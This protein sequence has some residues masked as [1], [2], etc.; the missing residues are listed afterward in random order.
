MNRRGD[1]PD[2]EQRLAQAQ[3]DA[4]SSSNELFEAISALEQTLHGARHA[5]KSLNSDASAAAVLTAWC[6]STALLQQTL[7][8]LRKSAGTLS[9]AV[10]T[11]IVG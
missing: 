3:R 8:R 10:G 1:R 4:Q 6:G 9:D 11:I 7:V 2:H 5:L